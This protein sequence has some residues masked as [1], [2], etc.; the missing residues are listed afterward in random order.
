MDVDFLLS[1]IVAALEALGAFIDFVIE[2]FVET[3]GGNP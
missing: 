2:R 3:F 1:P